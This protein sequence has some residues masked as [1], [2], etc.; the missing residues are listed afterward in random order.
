MEN[1][2]FK[3]SKNRV[4]DIIFDPFGVRNGLK[5]NGNLSNFRKPWWASRQ[6]CAPEL[7]DTQ[8]AAG[9]PKVVC[10]SF[11]DH[12]KTARRRLE[13]ILT[14][15]KTVCMS[16]K[17]LKIT[18]VCRLSNVRPYDRI[19]TAW[20][21]TAD[22]TTVNSVAIGRGRGAYQNIWRRKPS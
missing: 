16:A 20:R 15:L 11:E 19:K 2:S 21:S 7:T 3:A 22:L 17:R 1:F 18:D 10:R 6:R 14:W 5:I 13:I 8:S 9:L 4:F 12:L